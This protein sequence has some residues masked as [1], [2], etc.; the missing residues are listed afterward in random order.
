MT[1]L[2][3]ASEDA[4][5][6]RADQA[7]GRRVDLRL[8]RWGE[9]ADNTQ[10]GIRESFA[11]G[12]FAGVDPSRVTLE[13]QRHGGPLVGVGESIRE[14]DQDAVMTFRV[15]PT[16][17]GDEL[18]V[19][20]REGV[21][22]DAS[23]VFRPVKSRNRP[24]G[25]IERQG[26]D[27]R[28]VALL[29]RG[30]YPSAGLMAVREEADME[31][32]EVTD[33]IDLQPV[34]T[35]LDGIETRLGQI[36]VLASTPAAA[37]SPALYRCASLGD[38]TGQAYRGEL[39]ADLLQ[40]ALSDQTTSNN[41]GVVPP[42]WL[43]DVKRI[44]NLGRRGIS[45]FGGPRQLPATGMEL[46]WPYLNS[47]NTLIGVQGT[48][49]TEVT[50]ARVDIAKASQSLSTYAGGSDIS[51]QLLQRSS[52]SYREAYDRIMLGAWAATTDAAFCAALEAA[53]GTT[54]MA[55][56][57]MLGSNI[58][59]ANPSAA[60]DDILD[61][62]GAHG[63]SIGDAVVFTSLTGGTGLTAGR[64]YWVVDT[65]FGSTTFRVSDKPGGTAIGFSTDITAGNVAKVTDSGQR[66]REA[67]FQAS[68]AI[69]DATGQPAG[70]ILAATDVFLALA[71]LSGI[72]PPQP[73]GAPTY[74]TGVAQASTLQ[75]SASGL[76]IIRTPGVSAGKVIVSNSMAAGWYEDGPKWVTAEDVAKL[77]Q[78]MAV[79]SFNAAAVFVP[80]GV[81]ELTLI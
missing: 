57:G 25:V 15:A 29:E 38:F 55:A 51:Y 81:V 27:L 74:P 78:N 71:G 80:A 8:M 64:V 10:E 7:E 13:A 75:M 40:R 35:R 61:T 3:R 62:T 46:D 43:G 18:L 58:A 32:S 49:K 39:E 67:L 9:V 22:R 4:L 2:T 65:S 30:A 52:P 31:V 50:S 59:M 72:V 5:L 1:E 37:E 77:G 73:F 20:A 66:F 28:R 48:E 54:T 21:L 68:V 60:A 41:A 44:V 70:V 63:L 45:A 34:V 47:S 69:E 42:A 14:T 16:P 53:S 19:L 26:V 11:R 79:Y 33:T 76:T 24:D 36:E 6:E 17:A 23:V 56:R 12:A